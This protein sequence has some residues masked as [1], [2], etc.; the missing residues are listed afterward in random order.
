MF[1]S[2]NLL[3]LNALI[4]LL[5]ALKITE[6]NFPKPLVYK[7][8]IFLMNWIGRTATQLAQLEEHWTSEWKVVG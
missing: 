2:P 6:L 1:S 5:G 7:E 8:N 4:R 3:T